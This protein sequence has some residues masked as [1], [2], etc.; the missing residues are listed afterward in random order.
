MIVAPYSVIP[1]EAGNQNQS[2]HVCRQVSDSEMVRIG[3][4]DSRFHGNDS[5]AMFFLISTFESGLLY[6]TS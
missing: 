6:F 4:M 3:E 2:L 5:V 1:A